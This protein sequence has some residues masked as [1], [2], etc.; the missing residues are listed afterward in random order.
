MFV[1]QGVKHSK[2]RK[3]ART[4]LK[5]GIRKFSH[6]KWSKC[7]LLEYYIPLTSFMKSSFIPA[8]Y[9]PQFQ[10]HNFFDSSDALDSTSQTSFL[11]S[12]TEPSSS[13]P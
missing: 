5:G 2:L 7:Q 9:F 6:V 1:Q 3:E 13:D 12:L 4:L 11:L 8:I 10:I